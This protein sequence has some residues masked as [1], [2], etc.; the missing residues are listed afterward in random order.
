MKDAFNKVQSYLAHM[1][2]T[3]AELRSDIDME[4]VDRSNI[5]PETWEKMEYNIKANAV[6]GISDVFDILEEA[7]PE[8]ADEMLKIL[9][10]VEAEARQNENPRYAVRK[11]VALAAINFLRHELTQG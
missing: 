6:S 4:W 8:D 2:L 3:E 5:T 9:D 1:I 7:E 10:E 11:K